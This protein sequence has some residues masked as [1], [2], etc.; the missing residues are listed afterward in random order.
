MKAHPCPQD[1][2]RVPPDPVT[3]ATPTADNIAGLLKTFLEA[4][5]D[6]G[7]R[8]NALPM[9]MDKRPWIN[10]DHEEELEREIFGAIGTRNTPRAIEYINR[11][12]AAWE[13]VLWKA[14]RRKRK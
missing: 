14:T 12:R 8:W 6:V 3:R 4:F 7:A 5:E 11:W 10:P 2:R 1:I 9:P 13:A